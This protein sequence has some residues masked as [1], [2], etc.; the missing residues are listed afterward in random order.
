MKKNVVVSLF[1]VLLVHTAF[2]QQ[3]FKEYGYKVKVA[4]LSKGKYQEFF[5]QD[6][7]IQIGSVIIDQHTGKVVSFVT[8]DTVYSE[9]TLQPELASRWLSP[10]PMSEK[11]FSFSPYNFVLSNPIRFIDPDGT[12]V[13]PTD[14]K[15]LAA[16]KNTLSEKEAKYVKLDKNGNIKQNRLER[17]AKKLG[18]GSD[19]FKALSTL[20]KSDRTYNVAVSQ[21]FKTKDENGNVVTD[22]LGEMTRTDEGK[23]NGSFGVTLTPDNPDGTDLSP[24]VD[25]WVIINP[26][27]PERDQVETMAHEAFGHAYF[28]EL[29]KQGQNVN[30]YHTYEAD[31]VDVNGTMEITYKD[32]NTQLREQINKVQKLALNHYDQRIKKK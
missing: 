24:D 15:A 26:T 16:I 8:V 3:P 6:S 25:V 27:A 30:P 21:E 10:D 29:N 1:A 18:G 17:G 13:K 31:I 20:S 12:T 2:A 32:S 23:L 5:D 11:Y 22:N 19:N 7:L 9:A 14:D 28:Y 4:T